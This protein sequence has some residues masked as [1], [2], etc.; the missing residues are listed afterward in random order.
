LIF[1]SYTSFYIK[2]ITK[3]NPKEGKT[4][5]SKIYY[6]KVNLDFYKMIAEVIV[7]SVFLSI[8]IGIKVT[9]GI[10]KNRKM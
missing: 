8:Y 1:F 7:L 5:T 4:T 2:G 9:G 3:Y 6:K 10:R